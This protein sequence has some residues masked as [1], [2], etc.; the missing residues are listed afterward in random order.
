MRLILPGHTSD[1]AVTVSNQ[2]AQWLDDLIRRTSPHNNPSR[3]YP[4]LQETK[5]TF[6]GTVKEFEIFLGTNSWKKVRSA[7][8][9]LV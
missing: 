9:L 7:G 5:T 3:P 8:L 4:L 6:P 2:Q 1:Q